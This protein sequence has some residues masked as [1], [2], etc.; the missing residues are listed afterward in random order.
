MPEEI[1]LNQ[2]QS[3]YVDLDKGLKELQKAMQ[4]TTNA[5][6]VMPIEYDPQ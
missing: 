4:T 5:D 2:L 1:T 3:Q 6:V